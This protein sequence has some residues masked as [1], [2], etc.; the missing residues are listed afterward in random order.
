MSFSPLLFREVHSVSDLLGEYL[1]AL[2]FAVK[3]VLLKY[4]LY[5]PC[6]LLCVYFPVFA[7]QV[8]KII[9]RVSRY[10]L[11]ALFYVS[12]VHSLLDVVLVIALQ[13]ISHGL[14]FLLAC[15]VVNHS[16]NH[17]VPDFL[18]LRFAQSLVIT[19]E[20]FLQCCEC[21]SVNLIA[22]PDSS[23]KRS[24][25]IDLQGPSHV[26][27][28]RTPELSEELQYLC[29]RKGASRLLL[30]TFTSHRCGTNR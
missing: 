26:R 24:F 17:H 7:I 16:R 28:D 1:S 25:L 6:K 13:L 5:E 3:P 15:R 23:I 29:N 30:G 11:S 12:I 4:F 14:Y 18:L 2:V 20:A 21:A 19:A 22:R 27:S 8:I 9:D 10:V